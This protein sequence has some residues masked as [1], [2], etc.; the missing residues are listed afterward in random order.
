MSQYDKLSLPAPRSAD[1]QLGG[2]LKAITTQ[3]STL[4]DAFG[5]Q[6]AQLQHGFL[7]MQRQM[8][9]LDR[10]RCPTL[11]VLLPEP[12]S[13]AWHSVKG[14]FRSSLR[15]HLLCE[16]PGAPHL[17]LHPGLE[18]SRP[19]EFLRKC[20]PVVRLMM[21][22]LG[23]ALASGLTAVS[24]HSFGVAAAVDAGGQALLSDTTQV[25]C[26]ACFR[27]LL[28]PLPACVA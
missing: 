11:F 28:C 25:W 2:A 20:A 10:K 3:Q 24:G 23:T 19:K 5:E 26:N 15:L 21:K 9:A 8:E 12:G 17:T 16:C 4:V 14:F 13:G 18:V 6:Q 27:S 1:S 7:A 22:F